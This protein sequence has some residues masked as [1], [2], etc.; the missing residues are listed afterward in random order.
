MAKE[1]QK[2]I[3]TIFISMIVMMMGVV[4]HS[5]AEEEQKIFKEGNHL[6]HQK[7][8]AKALKKYESIV[9]QNYAVYCNMASAY[10]GK[11]QNVLAL[12]Y[13]KKAQKSSYGCQWESV[14]GRIEEIEKNL[15]LAKSHDSI[16]IFFAR[17]VTCVSFLCWQIL[18]IMLFL[19]LIF[20]WRVLKGMK[21][22]IA[23]VT[24][25]VLLIFTC[26]VWYCREKISLESTALVHAHD[27]KIF[28][29]PHDQYH[30]VAAI[31]P[32]SQVFI[33][34]EKNDWCRIVAETAQGQSTGWMQAS[35]LSKI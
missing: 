7:K 2:N 12:L 9:H 16:T 35:Q 1:T 26:F 25:I 13:L 6:Y 20:A 4:V 30:V 11:K 8:Y 31:V 14:Q 10:E 29:G 27:A 22:T 32:G 24:L 5:S 17:Y 33:K 34:Q 28:V 15:S 21:K 3:I 23:T 19:T 18:F